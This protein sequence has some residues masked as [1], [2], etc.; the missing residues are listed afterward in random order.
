MSVT[1]FQAINP[2]KPTSLI[3]TLEYWHYEIKTYLVERL[4]DESVID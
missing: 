4:N 2:I 1:N 3:Q